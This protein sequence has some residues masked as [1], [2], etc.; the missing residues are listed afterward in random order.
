MCMEML[1]FFFKILVSSATAHFTCYMSIRFRVRTLPPHCVLKPTIG[2]QN[3]LNRKTLFGVQP[4]TFV[5][6]RIFLVNL[7]SK[8]KQG[9]TMSSWSS[10]VAARVQGRV[11]QGSKRAIASDSMTILVIFIDFVT[12]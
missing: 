5:F 3:K 9:Q 7:I 4:R 6:S 8:T 1:I 11:Q 10:R 2:V 12:N